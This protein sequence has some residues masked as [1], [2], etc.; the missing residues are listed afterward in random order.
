MRIKDILDIELKLPSY[1]EPKGDKTIT[2]NGQHDVKDY[3]TATVNVPEP[4]GSTNITTNG[5]FNV[6]NYAEAIVNVSGGGGGE[7]NIALVTPDSSS[8]R[9]AGFLSSNFVFVALGDG[10]VHTNRYAGDQTV[11]GIVH[12]SGYDRMCAIKP[13]DDSTINFWSADNSPTTYPQYSIDTNGK[14]S[15]SGY[16]WSFDY[17]DKY[18]LIYW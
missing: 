11:I 5:T 1:P 7:V 16:S 9:H 4:S 10:S 17:Y 3:A 14:L 12:T 18:A 13:V 2:A 15:L 6:K 8:V